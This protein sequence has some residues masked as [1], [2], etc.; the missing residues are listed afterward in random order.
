MNFIY[1]ACHKI[2]IQVMGNHL[3]ITNTNKIDLLVVE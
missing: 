3:T 2:K 1:V